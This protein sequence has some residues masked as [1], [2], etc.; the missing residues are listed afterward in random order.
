MT[1]IVLDRSSLGT[2]YQEEAKRSIFLSAEP[3][4][5]F[6]PFENFILAAF[7]HCCTKEFQ[8]LFM[9]L[10]QLLTLV[11]GQRQNEA[12]FVWDKYCHLKIYAAEWR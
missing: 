8:D 12:F 11:R 2:S 10:Y 5:F 7:T 4:W 3:R 1:G 6:Y 9:R